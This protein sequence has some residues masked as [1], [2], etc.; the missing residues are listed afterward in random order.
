MLY[1]VPLLAGGFLQGFALN[2]PDVPFL[3]VVAI[4]KPYLV[5]RSVAA[6]ILAAGH[7]AFFINFGWILARHF[8]PYREPLPG[9][10]GGMGAAK[11]V[12]QE[13]AAV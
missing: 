12:A 2:N 7:V 11:P 9:I 13:V 6:V 4:T 1:V 8:G 5:N 10:L 3:K